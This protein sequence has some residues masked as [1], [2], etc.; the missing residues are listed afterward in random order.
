MTKLTKTLINSNKIVTF[1]MKK[2]K[3]KQRKYIYYSVALIMTIKKVDEM[4]LVFVTFITQL[5][6][7]K[8]KI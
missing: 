1:K 2:Q 7:Y 4:S 8:I 6:K 5:F 3:T